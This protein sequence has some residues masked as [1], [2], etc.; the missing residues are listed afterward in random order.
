[1]KE[2]D[3]FL[4]M[5]KALPK[6][7]QDELLKAVEESGA[8]SADDFVSDIF[9]GDCPQCGSSNT[10]DCEE[11]PEIEDITLGLCQDCG[12]M[13]CTECG[14]T[15]AKGSA[16]EHWE[17]CERCT[18]KKDTF[19]D[20]GI[21]PWECEKISTFATTDDEDVFHICA[22][23]NKTIAG[24]TEVFSLGA[25]AQK[26]TDMKRYRGSAVRIQ[27]THDARTVSA[28]VPTSGSQARRAGNDVL[29]ML[30]S[31]RCAKQL[32]RALVKEKFTIV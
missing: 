8:T 5:F 29:F 32:R 31:E 2:E 18:K 15:V 6:D 28:M 1:M 20:C 16:C 7:I 27:L 3:D 17:I 21:P 14:R 30:C 11:V 13:W 12:H 4:E 24:D 22:W 25:K 10:G 23:C 26:G 19:G 9:V